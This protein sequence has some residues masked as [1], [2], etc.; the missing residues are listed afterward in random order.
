ML[1]LTLLE[2]TYTI[3]RVGT[4]YQC[5][6]C[7][8]QYKREAAYLWH[9]QTIMI[10]NTIPNDCY[11]LSVNA[12]DEFSKQSIT[13]LYSNSLFFAVFGRYI[14][15]FNL[16][17]QETKFF[18]HHQRTFVLTYERPSNPLKESDSLKEPDSLEET[19]PLDKSD[20][21]E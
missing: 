17:K 10:Y 15:Y 19:D 18:D 20:S 2:T 14:H 4:S 13:F 12:I 6:I 1:S 7:N 9:Q 3:P 8:K 5:S 16:K 11:T 21:L